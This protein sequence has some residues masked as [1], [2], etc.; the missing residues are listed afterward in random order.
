MSFMDKI[1]GYFGAEGSYRGY[2]HAFSEGP[3]GG[4][5]FHI[6]GIDD[7]F[8]RGLELPH[9]V[10]GKRI[11]AAYA[12]VMA[13]ARAVSQ[14]KPHHKRMLPSGEWVNVDD[15]AVAQIIRNPNSYET[16][17]QYIVNAVA[18][19]LFDGESFSLATRDD[20]GQ[21]ASIHRLSSRTCSPYVVEGELFYSVSTGNPF[22]PEDMQYMAP[23]RDVLHLRVHTPRH[24]LVGESPIKAAS[25]AAGINVSLSHSQAAFF[26]QMS[27]PSGVLSTDAVLNKEQLVSLREAWQQ[28][29]TRMNQG[30]IPILSGGLKF[31][32]MSIS[33]QDAELMDAQRFSV[34]EIAR[35]FG[36][37]LPIIG[38]MTNS[39]LNNV[40]QL[41][42]FWLSVSLSSLLENI[43]Q[44]MGRLFRLPPNE[45]IDFDVTGLLRADFQTRIDG[46]TKAV[47]GGLY[48]VNEARAKENLH[49]VENGDVPYLQAQMVQ[50]GTMPASNQPQA[51]ED[52]EDG[53]ELAFDRETFRKA[54]R[55]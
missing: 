8:Q 3:N 11:P 6:G 4:N 30:M 15:S 26:T 5:L 47:Q 21:V 16:W 13:N 1:K 32:Q 12:S 20:R 51:D 39:T 25:L 2:S 10:D 54:L 38:D 36:V 34:E 45:K 9:P 18:Q 43:E 31:Q 22:L 55:K 33:S 40:E 29:S 44:S 28:Q 14:C 52:D 53:V 46:L 42:S 23:A 50:L 24:N 17:A 27:R 48:T 35:C 41:I 19:L 37:P 49:A 7:G